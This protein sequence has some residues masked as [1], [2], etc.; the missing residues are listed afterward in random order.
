MYSTLLK[1]NR[2]GEHW[3]YARYISQVSTVHH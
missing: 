1:E 2:V 3:E